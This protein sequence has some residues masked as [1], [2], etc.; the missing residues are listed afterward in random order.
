VAILPFERYPTLF[1]DTSSTVNLVE[2]EEVSIPAVRVIF[3]SALGIVVLASLAEMT[4]DGSA[5]YVLF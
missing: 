1:C 4:L 3:V 5:F 2:W